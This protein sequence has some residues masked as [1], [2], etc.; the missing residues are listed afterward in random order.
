MSLGTMHLP[1]S[2]HR[3][4]PYWDYTRVGTAENI[5]VDE[6]DAVFQQIIKGM[7][8]FLRKEPTEENTLSLDAYVHS[9]DG[10]LSTLQQQPQ[11]KQRPNKILKPEQIDKALD[12]IVNRSNSYVMH[13]RNDFVYG[14]SGHLFHNGISE[15]S[16]S[17]LVGKL[18]KATNDEDI[19]DRLDVVTETYKKGKAGKLVKGI[20]QLKYLLAKY[21][22]ENDTCVNEIID[23]LNGSLGISLNYGMGISS[24]TSPNSSDLT[25]LGKE[26]PIAKVMVELAELNGDIFF[27]DTFGE[28]YAIINSVDNHTHVEV[29]SMASK[30]F[31]YHLRILLKRN[32]NKRIISNDSVEKAIETLKAEAIVEGRTIPLRL[33]V[34]WKKRNEII[35]YDPTDDSWSCIAIGRDIGTWQILPAGSLTNYPIAELRNPNSKLSDQPVLFT[36]YSQVSQMMPDRNYP[37]DIMQQFIDRCTNIRDPRDQLLFKA[38]LVTLFIPDIAHPILLL[39]GVKGAAKSILETEVKRIIDPSQ[40]ELLIL[41]NNLKE[42]IIQLARHYYNAY[43]NVIKIPQWLSSIICAATT[44]AGFILRTLYTTADETPL[45]FKRCFALS[46]IGASLTEDDALERSISINHPKIEKQD[47]KMEEKILAEFDSLLPQLLGYI[48]D[49]IAKTM[50]EKDKLEQTQELDDKLERMADFSFWGEAAARV[51]GYKPMEFMNAYSENLRNQSRDAVNF[52]ALADI[53]RN[54]CDE[55]L[56]TKHEVEY[57]IPDLL[58]KVR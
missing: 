36:R 17:N 43:D 50:Q 52:N 25:Q 18:C 15:I 21:N 2:R 12:I 46:S 26:D 35:Y 40:I 28:P 54:I 3:S 37:S 34:A 47:R 9:N 8:G 19:N 23:E 4:Y 51:M 33:R 11:Q 45:K 58:T 31:A 13:S 29:L 53:M 49:V 32:K 22:E 10:T 27:K 41:N 1:P 48:F 57:S 6:E 38:Y 14:L 7:S 44:G 5:Y 24:T 16:A 56:A 20:S 39:K 30:K 42:F 55:E